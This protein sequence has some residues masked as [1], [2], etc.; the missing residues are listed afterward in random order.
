MSV[1]R[2]VTALEQQQGK[3]WVFTLNNY[4]DADIIELARLGQTTQFSYLCYGKE[5]GESGTP[6]LQGYFCLA[7]KMRLSGLKHLLGTRY[8]FEGIPFS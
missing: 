2:R 4:A 6:H 7:K 3:H 8:H 1:K 5:V